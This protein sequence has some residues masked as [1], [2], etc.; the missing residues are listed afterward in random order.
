MGLFEV[1]DEATVRVHIHHLAAL[2]VLLEEFKLGELCR[3]TMMLT[4][5]FFIL[6][7]IFELLLVLVVSIFLLLV[8]LL[9]VSVVFLLL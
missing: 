9:I 8:L 4:G 1:A 6:T 2:L 7:T 3:S 5:S